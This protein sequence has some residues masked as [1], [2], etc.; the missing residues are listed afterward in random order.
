MTWQ[1]RNA[2]GGIKPA[3]NSAKYQ[4]IRHQRG[5]ENRQRQRAGVSLI[6]ET[7]YER[8]IM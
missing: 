4:R 1:Q 3:N 6:F 2:H 8:V 7:L 5:G